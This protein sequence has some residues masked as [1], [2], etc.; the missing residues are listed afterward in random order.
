MERAPP[1]HLPLLPP[2]PGLPSSAR[3][4]MI[5]L[6]VTSPTAAF[7]DDLRRRGHEPLLSTTRGTVRIEV[8]GGGRAERWLI[9]IDRGTIEVADGGG[10]AG[11]TLRADRAFFDDLVRGRE[12]AVASVL[13]GALDVE[14]DWALLLLFQ[15]LFPGPN[16]DEGAA[17]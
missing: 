3:R 2:A 15:R 9:A 7:V 11:C 16:D 6:D 1:L 14:G 5:A 4:S 12:N 10:P 17:A 8:T 13:R